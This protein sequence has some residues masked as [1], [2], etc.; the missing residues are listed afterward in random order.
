M[1]SAGRQL[2]HLC[3]ASSESLFRIQLIRSNQRFSPACSQTLRTMRTS[4]ALA[5]IEIR[6]LKNGRVKDARALLRRRQREKDAK[7]LLEGQR[8]I[9]D[10]LQSGVSPR[11]FFYT[12]EAVQKC[13]TN[14]ILKTEICEK[15][16]EDVLVSE[17]VM[18]S[19]SDTVNPQVRSQQSIEYAML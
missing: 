2:P 18:R 7:I 16:A 19:L 1:T 3:F 13:E 5:D 15:G 11:E 6:S 17:E 8:L 12:M 4:G 14:Q 9:S 10:A